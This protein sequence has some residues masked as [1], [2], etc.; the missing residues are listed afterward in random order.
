MEKLKFLRQKHNKRQAD[1]ADYLGITYQAYAHYEKGRHQP[2]PETLKK[3]AD[4]FY[5]SVDYLLEQKE[6]PENILTKDEAQML[7][8]YRGFTEQQKARALAYVTA[9]KQENESKQI[10]KK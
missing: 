3:L 7:D 10:K 4:Y 8:I 1:V 2:D 9:I 5:V 6:I